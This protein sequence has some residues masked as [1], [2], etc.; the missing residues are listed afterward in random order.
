MKIFK[1]IFL[2]LITNIA[3]IFLIWVIIFVLERYLWINISPN[4]ESWITP[5][6]VFSAIYWFSWAFISLAISRWVAKK[7]YSIE[8]I[9]ESE[10]HKYPSK[11]Q[12]LF[13]KTKEF[14]NQ[15]WIKMPEF[16]IYE[17]SDAN[18]FATWPSK[19]KS[20]VAF[21]SGIIW[22]MDQNELEWVLAHEMSHIVNWDM[23]TLTLVQ[24]IINTFVIFLARVIA[25]FID[26]ALNKDEDWNISWIAYHLVVIVLEIVFS[27]LASIVVMAYS[28]KREFSADKD[29]A[30]FT[31]K[32]NMIKALKKLKQLSFEK[33]NFKDDSL[34][35][36]MISWKKSYLS[37][38][39]SHPDLDTRIEK[40]E[41]MI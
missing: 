3:I 22:V 18:A 1:R 7:I 28:R 13:F 27:I 38:F 17:S 32:Q 20:L 4:M 26:M 25:Y 37:I 29:S 16:G 21:S 14:A 5:L 33:E 41:N 19:N 30:F 9:Q 8:I 23:V 40:L 6:L 10:I 34:A 39:S 35:A 31:P 36:F 24:W 2:F 12:Y 11:I 15:K